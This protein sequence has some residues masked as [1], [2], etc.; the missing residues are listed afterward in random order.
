MLSEEEVTH[1]GMKER[2]VE[3][4]GFLHFCFMFSLSHKSHLCPEEW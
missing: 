3:M 4:K 2:K 1:E